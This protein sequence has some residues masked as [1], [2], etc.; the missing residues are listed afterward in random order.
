MK[1]EDVRAQGGRWRRLLEGP[2]PQWLALV[3]GAAGLVF[4]PLQ[5]VAAGYVLAVAVLVALH[6]FR[7]ARKQ[8]DTAA[9][10]ALTPSQVQRG[11]EVRHEQRFSL[12]R[13]KDGRVVLHLEE[14]FHSPTPGGGRYWATDITLPG[15]FGERILEAVEAQRSLVVEK[16]LEDGIRLAGVEVPRP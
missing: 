9:T 1:R 13:R 11:V 12:R 3:M 8:A 2:G 5:Y 10:P 6:L 14:L 7:R 15:E 4:I 16:S